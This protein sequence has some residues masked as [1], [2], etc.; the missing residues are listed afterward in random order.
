MASFRDL[1]QLRGISWNLLT[2]L[3][4]INVSVFSY[5]FDTSIYAN[6]QAMDGECCVSFPALRA[7]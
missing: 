1:R 5:G 3:I 7:T 4:I 6:I 2:A